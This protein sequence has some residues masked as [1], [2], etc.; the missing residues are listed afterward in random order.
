MGRFKF[1]VG[2]KIFIAIW[3]LI[4]C[5]PT[6]REL[7]QAFVLS[8][9]RGIES[10]DDFVDQLN[11][12]RSNDTVGE[13]WRAETEYRRGNKSAIEAVATRHPEELRVKASQLFL[14]A[15]QLNSLKKARQQPDAARD[16][17]WLQSAQIA[18]DASALE[19]DNV[20]WPWM[21]AAFEFAGRRNAAALR[22]FERAARCTRYQDYSATINRERIE[23]LQ[24]QRHLAWEQKLMLSS[25]VGFSQLSPMRNASLGASQRA[26]TLREKGQIPRALAIEV[27]VLN[28]NS[29]ARRDGKYAITATMGQNAG[30]AS[31]DEF[32]GITP[33]PLEKQG[34]VAD[35]EVHSRELVKAWTAFVT[36]HTRPE[37]AS[38]A[39]FLAEPSVNWIFRELYAND[40]NAQIELYGLRSPLGDFTSV[41][42]YILV[43]LSVI[44]AVGALFWLG[45]SALQFKA[46][47]P[48]RGQIAL[49]ANFS[50]WLFATSLIVYYAAYSEHLDALKG[51]F[52]SLSKVVP[53]I[54]ALAIICW[55][56]P[57]EFLG[58]F[59]GRVQ[60]KKELSA[61]A[62]TRLK[63]WLIR[64]LWFI[65]VA[66]LVLMGL[67]ILWGGSW[68]DIGSFNFVAVVMA[69]I[70]MALSWRATQRQYKFGWQ[71]AHKSAGV[72]VLMWSA[73]F[74]LMS[75]GVWPL[76]AQFNRNLARHS[77]IGEIAWMREQIA[78]R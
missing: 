36:L 6:V 60:A 20:F 12:P 3:L 15:K 56:L 47:Q 13:A 48:T 19:P 18:R 37:L 38:K 55:F 27:G 4:L 63:L 67:T 61:P 31:L 30:V 73:V 53:A 52:W 23:W 25:A 49:C 64:L 58:W 46:E 77:Q 65:A 9:L 74:L 75:I 33:I 2:V 14:V 8:E 39:K 7:P 54:G 34:Y 40:E 66:S 35:V 10:P 68:L 51:S 17:R 11:L 70:A 1:P 32:L 69:L 24:N 57:V 72:L 28:A 16:E 62:L 45:G 22:A 21:E 43:V 44:I 26:K 50:F 42:P 78:K 71:L 59:R 76:R 29:L 5:V 41:A